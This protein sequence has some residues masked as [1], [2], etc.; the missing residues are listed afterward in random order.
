M[1]RP[2]SALLLAAL[3]LGAAPALPLAAQSVS[4]AGADATPIPKGSVR[5]RLAGQWD[6]HDRVF[7]DSGSRRLFGAMA[8]DNLGTRALPQ[9]LDAERA[10]QSLSGVSTFSLSLG[11]LEASGDVR[12]SVTPIAL[13]VGITSRLSIGIVVPYVESRNNAL[14]I[15][16]R[17]G[18]GANVGQNPAY[19]TTLGASARAV[20]GSLLRQLTA[21]RAQLTA[22]ISRCASALELN[23]DAIRANPTGAQQALTQATATLT[24]IGALYGDSVRGGSPVVPAVGSATQTAIVARLASLR[25]SMQGFGIN[26]IADGAAP[27]AA[28]IINGPGAIPRIANDTAYGLNYSTLGGTRRAG[29]GDID[30]TATFLWLNT[31]GARPVQWLNAKGFG[32]RSQVTGGFRFG[33]AGAD[34][35]NDAF[36]V[37][38]GEGANAILARS[39]TDIVLNQWFWMSGTVR[40]VQ[41]LTDDVVLR[42]PLLVDTML[43]APSAVGRVSR[44]LGRRMELE[45]APRL[46]LGRF[47][48][49][50]GGYLIR[51]HD[52][53][54]LTYAA[55]SS[56][57]SVSA[58]PTTYQ[59]YL[60][61]MTFSTL[62]SYVR[63]RSK[64]PIEVSYVHTE[65]LTGTGASVPAVATDRL[66]LRV[67]TGFPR[68]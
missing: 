8:T 32:L 55:S 64:W 9:L 33:T 42:Q 30:V 10:I 67:Y 23:C 62:A 29:I 20:N 14:L 28:T 46:T 53:D 48:G 45:V 36:D 54:Q 11:T 65:P 1:P 12:Q 58:G 66:E 7:T 59:A 25:S 24:S 57:P 51:R 63:N 35:T 22:E 44:T 60:V 17:A 4:G 68:R 6:A 19:S 34:R 18:T 52:A 26:A 27:A 40:V 56:L 43:F 5:I 13:D 50:S 49:I 15:L 31:L 38:I 16:N 37:P 3:C 47:F 61:G 41:P 21:A 39:T 2:L